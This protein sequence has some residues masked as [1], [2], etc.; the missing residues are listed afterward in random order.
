MRKMLFVFPI[1]RLTI[2]FLFWFEANNSTFVSITW[3]PCKPIDY[4][5]FVSAFQNSPKLIKQFPLGTF[6]QQDE[7]KFEKVAI[8][9]DGLPE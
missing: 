1:K 2:V 5:T 7:R 4:T 3:G 6:I 9:G 8:P